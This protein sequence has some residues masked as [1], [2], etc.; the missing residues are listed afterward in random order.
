MRLI[1]LAPLATEVTK[2]GGLGFIGGG[3]DLGS[4]DGHLGDAAV[5]VRQDHNLARLYDDTGVL[6]VGFGVLTWGADLDVAA[7]AV[8]KWVP[9]AVWLFAP[10]EVHNLAVWTRRLRASGRGKTSIWIQ[11]GTVMEALEVARSCQPDVLVVQGQDAGGHGLEL[12]ASIVTLLPEVRDTLLDHGFGD[13]PLV[14]AGG[15]GDGRGAA[16]ALVLGA[17]GVVLG[18]RLLATE[19]AQISREYQQAVVDAKDGGINTVRTK[20]YDYLR[21]I[22]AWPRRYGGRSLIN[23]SFLDHAAGFPLEENKKLYEKCL[24]R[25][26]KGWGPQGRLTSYAGTG[27]GLI[28]SVKDAGEVV[29]EVQQDASRHLKNSSRLLQ[30]LKAHL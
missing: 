16:A 24:E 28:K 20:V 26:D 9:A 12:G 5:L 29:R 11:I 10:R 22:T 15:I 1:C 4:L 6:P 25:G 3:S 7:A 23:Q 14:A 17:D 18:T 21:G 2:A 13:I 27:V 8:E 19:E 30:S